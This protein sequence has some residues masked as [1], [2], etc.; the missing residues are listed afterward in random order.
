MTSASNVLRPDRVAA[1]DELL[2]AVDPHLHPG[3]RPQAGLV[4]AVAPFRDQPLET[5]RLHGM[6]QV[7]QTGVEDA[8]VAHRLGE[9]GQKLV[10]EQ[11]AA[12]R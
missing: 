12:R 11:R 10:L 5:L 4:A 2:A 9:R 1:D 3:A 6:D 7:A 8:G